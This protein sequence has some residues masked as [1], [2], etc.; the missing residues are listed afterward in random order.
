[1]ANPRAREVPPL[2]KPS[3]VVKPMLRSNT[4]ATRSVLSKVTTNVGVTNRSKS[5][6]E[7]GGT[8]QVRGKGGIGGQART[9]N[10]AARPSGVENET[11]L[12]KREPT[13]EDNQG[14]GTKKTRNATTR[15]P[16]TTAVSQNQPQSS[17]DATVDQ[18]PAVGRGGARNASAVMTRA[19]KGANVRG[20]RGAI[21]SQ[22][23]QVVEL[24]EDSN[25][26]KTD[27]YYVNVHCR[28]T[29]VTATATT[30]QHTVKGYVASKAI[31]ATVTDAMRPIRE[32]T[33]TVAKQNFTKQYGTALPKDSQLALVPY[34]PEADIDLTEDPSMCGEYSGDIYIYHRQ[35]E[36]QGH[37][38]VCAT[39]LNHQDDINS[40]HRRVLVDWLAQ[41]HYKYRLLQETMLLTVD[42]LDRYLQVHGYTC[43]YISG[44]IHMYV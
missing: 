17:S 19:K 15:V 33:A 1:M 4:V 3:A 18:R 35:L 36:E 11:T 34:K 26:R 10:V 22:L 8:K 37:Y 38:A 31:K 2:T 21:T 6:A 40:Q 32:N 13:D 41:V 23:P 25:V 12:V 9:K 39:F 5:V 7:G 43:I 16:K 24:K 44:H 20:V 30:K 14:K 29:K 27:G 28:K 42:I